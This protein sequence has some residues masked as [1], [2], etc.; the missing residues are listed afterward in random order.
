MEGER[1]AEKIVISNRCENRLLAPDCQD[2]EGGARNKER[3]RKM[4]YDRMLRV[5]CEERGLQIEGIRR[6][7]S[8]EK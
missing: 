2:F 1:G 6:M 3:N 5:A 7:G 8:R 4:N